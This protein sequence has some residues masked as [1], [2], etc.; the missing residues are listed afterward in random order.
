MKPR[1]T[2]VF[3]LTSGN[4]S[5]VSTLV[6]LLLFPP[7]II[8]LWFPLCVGFVFQVSFSILLILYNGNEICFL[9]W[10]HNHWLYGI[11]LSPYCSMSKSLV[12]MILCAQLLSYVQ[13]FATPW[14]VGPPGSSHGILQARILEWVA[15]PFSRG[16]FWLS[17]APVLAG[18]FFTTEPPGKLLMSFLY[19][20]PFNSF[21]M[22]TEQWSKSSSWLTV[23]WT[24]HLSGLPPSVSHFPPDS[25]T[26]VPVICLL[27]FLTLAAY[28]YSVFGWNVF[29]LSI[30][31]AP[32]YMVFKDSPDLRLF[33]CIYFLHGIVVI[34]AISCLKTIC[35][36]DYG[37]TT[38]FIWGTRWL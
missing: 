1:K 3:L 21:P 23:L 11:T 33:H 15:I 22:F 34:Y 19:L 8:N 18:R 37:N 12:N 4:I 5:S 16:S 6:Y 35:I 28:S 25:R 27:S 9:Y 29:S 17:V 24:A 26:W 14:T 36:N 38:G 13:L 30:W 32:P 31:P 10:F 7:S 2:L 20:K